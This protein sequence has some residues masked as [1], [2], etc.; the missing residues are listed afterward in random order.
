[1]FTPVYIANSP[2]KWVFFPW[3]SAERIW[4]QSAYHL[5]GHLVAGAAQMGFRVG[6]VE[7]SNPWGYPRI[8]EQL[9]FTLWLFNIAMV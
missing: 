7:N 4:C 2:G 3:P 1:M 8:I 5:P 6:H 9:W